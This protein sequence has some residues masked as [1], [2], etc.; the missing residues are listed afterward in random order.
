M[1]ICNSRQPITCGVFAIR[2]APKSEFNCDLGYIQMCV[3]VFQNQ[4][5]DRISAE[6][7]CI[8]SQ[9]QV[10]S[11]VNAISQL[12][13][14][15]V[16][17]SLWCTYAYVLC[18]IGFWHKGAVIFFGGGSQ[19][20]KKSPSIKLRP[21]LFLQQNFYGPPTNTP[22][23]NQAKIVLKSIFLNKIN[24]LSVVILWLPTFWSSKILWPPPP[25]VYLGP[26]LSK[27]MTAF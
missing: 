12:L 11:D 1:L 16:G 3:I 21:P 20:Y 24:T 4:I 22:P 19:I 10:G 2:Q 27:K 9:S 14:T 25:P 17:T 15:C 13:G 5:S 18:G 26:T 8:K 6:S 7:E 23:P